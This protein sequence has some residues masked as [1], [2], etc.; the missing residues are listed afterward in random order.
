M[1]GTT[2]KKD[3][4]EE[5]RKDG[6]DDSSARILKA[7]KGANMYPLGLSHGDAPQNRTLSTESQHQ[8]SQLQGSARSNTLE[9]ICVVKLLKRYRCATGKTEN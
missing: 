6:G 5:R 3:G 2:G 8:L 7:T 4:W 1:P 9:S